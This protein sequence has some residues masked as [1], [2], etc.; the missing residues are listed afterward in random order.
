DCKK[1]SNLMERPNIFKR[2]I[3]AI[4]DWTTE[5]LMKQR[6]GPRGPLLIDFNRLCYEI[7]PGDVLLIAGRS[8]VSEVIKLIT[9]SQWSHAALYIG[10]LHDIESD[11]LREEVRKHFLGA[12]TEQLLIE[13]VMGKG[14]IVTPISHYKEDHI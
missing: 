3:K 8:R 13:S 12:P 14:T 7:R 4:S 10:R 5:A 1:G 9:Q 2:F 11:E 6:T